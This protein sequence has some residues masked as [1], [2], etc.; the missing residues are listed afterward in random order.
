M[1]TERKTKRTFWILLFLVL[2][3]C[4]LAAL[5]MSQTLHAQAFGPRAK[6]MYKVVKASSDE[7]SLQSVVDIFGRDGWELVSHYNDILIFKK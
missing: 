6:F 3:N 1:I 5:Q 4:A 2:I 7:Q